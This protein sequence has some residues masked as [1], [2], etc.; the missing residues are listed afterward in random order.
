MCYM[1]IF[2]V[3]CE[4]EMIPDT[5]NFSAAKATVT[6]FGLLVFWSKIHFSVKCSAVLST[7]EFLQTLGADG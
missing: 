2:L 4:P 5:E 6:S 1:E 3:C 7:G